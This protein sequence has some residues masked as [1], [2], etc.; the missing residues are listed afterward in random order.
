MSDGLKK[1]I[2]KANRLRLLGVAGTKQVIEKN[3]KYSDAIRKVWEKMLIDYP[4][5]VHPSQY[6]DMLLYVRVQDKMTRVAS[7]TPER[8]AKDDESP[9][10]DIRGYG[11][12]GEEKDL[13]E[14]DEGLD[15]GKY[16]V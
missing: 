2:R 7:H 10:S 14:G 12:L 8:R 6:G 15:P 5:G 9:W 16:E 3:D 1:R 11:L 13:D 4:D